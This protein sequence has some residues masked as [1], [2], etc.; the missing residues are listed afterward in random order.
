[1]LCASNLS[2]KASVSPLH[3]TFSVFFSFSPHVTASVF[4]QKVGVALAM[5]QCC[6]HL[7]SCEENGACWFSVGQIFA[8]GRHYDIIPASQSEMTTWHD[9]SIKQQHQ[10]GSAA[11]EPNQFHVDLWHLM[12]TDSIRSVF[13]TVLLSDKGNFPSENSLILLWRTTSICVYF[14]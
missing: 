3:N 10:Y 8:R 7:Q 6:S 11:M 13:K 9:H 14:A 2:E 4:P 1:M 12:T 5:T